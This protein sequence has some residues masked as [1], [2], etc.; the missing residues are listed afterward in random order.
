MKENPYLD[1]QMYL[2]IQYK[3]ILVER[4]FYIGAGNLNITQLEKLCKE[5][6]EYIHQQ[7][8]IKDNCKRIIADIKK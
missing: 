1:D 4:P 8:I 3:G 2:P 5:Y 6:E 7:T